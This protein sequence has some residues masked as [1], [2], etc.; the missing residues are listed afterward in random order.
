M[1]AHM[2]VLR[3]GIRDLEVSWIKETKN[4]DAEDNRRVGRSMAPILRMVQTN[5]ATVDAWRSN[6][7]QLQ[8]LF[9]KVEGLN[10]F[11]LVI[12]SGLLRDNKFGMLFRVG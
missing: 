5:D 7:P 8:Y 6:Y 1:L 3:F 10:E 4:W 12:V 11:M 9:D 2:F